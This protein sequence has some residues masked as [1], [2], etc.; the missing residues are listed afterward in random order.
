MG[1]GGSQHRIS[2]HGCCDPSPEAI[3]KTVL[4]G[5]HNTSFYDEITTE[6][7]KLFS[8]TFFR[9]LVVF[10][11]VDKY[12]IIF[13]ILQE[14]MYICCDPSLEIFCRNSPNEG[15]QCKFFTED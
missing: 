7:L 6:I 3:S 5:G 13:L 11:F 8:N 14:Y 12:G 2:L 10:I 15:L 9:S 4:A 1:G